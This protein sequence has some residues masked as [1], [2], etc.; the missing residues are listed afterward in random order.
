MKQVLRRLSRTTTAIVMMVALFMMSVGLA[1]AQEPAYGDGIIVDGDTSDW[2]LT[3]DFFANMYVAGNSNKQHLS[4]LYLRY[5]CS[6]NTLYALVLKETGTVEQSASD[7]WI[8]IN[9]VNDKRVNGSSGDDGTPPDF[10]WVFDNTTLL[11]YEASFTLAEGTYDIEAHLNI[12]WDNE[13]QTSSTG[14]LAQDNAIELT[15]DCP[16]PPVEVCTPGAAWMSE[17]S[18]ITI[19][20]LS[21]NSD[22]EGKT[23]VG[24]SLINSNSANFGLNFSVPATTPVLEI[25]GSGGSGSAINVNNGSVVV[26]DDNTITDASASPVDYDIN[27][28]RF[29]VNAGNSGATAST[30]GTLPAKAAQIKSDLEAWST[31]LAGLTANNSVTPPSGSPGPLNFEVN[32]KD[33][34]GVAVFNIAGS[35]LFNNSNVQQIEIKNNVNADVIIINVSGTTINWNHGNKVGSW[36]TSLNGRSKTIWN[37]PEAT[38]IDL[39]SKNF[40]GALLAPLAAVNAQA[41]IDGATAVKSLTTTSEVH[42]PVLDLGCDEEPPSSSITFIK[43]V[44]GGNASPTDWSFDITDGPQDIAHN[45]TQTLNT[46]NYII[47]E[48]GPEGYFLFGASGVCSVDNDTITLN[49]TTDGGTC[50]ITNAKIPE[51]PSSL[52]VTKTVN[53]S[54]VTP[55]EQQTFEICISGPSYPNG[56][57]DGACQDADFDGTTLSWDDLAEGEYIVAETNPGSEWTV[58]ITDSPATVVPGETAEVSVTNTLKTGSLDVTK[59]VNWNG[60]TPDEQQ[61]FEI[62]IS[63]PSYPNGDENGACQEADYDGETL[64]WNDLELG[65]YTVS[66]TNPGDEWT[67]EITGSPATVEADGTAEAT[68]TNTHEPPTGSITVVKEVVVGSTTSEFDFELEQPVAT[69]VGFVLTHGQD[70]TF[71]DLAPGEYVALETFPIGESDAWEAL[72]AEDI[73]CTSDGDST[74]EYLPFDDEADTFGVNVSLAAGDD[75]TCT[76]KNTEKPLTGS[77]EVTKYVSWNNVTPDESKTFEICIKGPSYPNG[78]EDGACQEADFDG[79]VL[80]WNKL[81]VGEYT[82]SETDPGDEWD[83]RITDSPATVVVNETVKAS[84]TNQYK[85][86]DLYVYKYHDLNGNGQYDYPDEPYLSDWEI[87]VYDSDEN[88]VGTVKTD[89]SGQAAFEYLLIGDYIV[90]ETQQD[91]WV[92]T[93]DSNDVFEFDG[94]ICQNQTIEEFSLFSVYF[95]NQKEIEPGKIT[96]IKFND[97]NQNGVKDDGEPFLADWEFTLKQG[98]T[99]IISDTT[100]VNG[101]VM[102]GDLEPGTYQVCE[103]MKDGWSNST[104]ICQEVTIGGGAAV[105]SAGIPSFTESMAGVRY[106]SFKNTGGEEVYLGLPDL[107]LVGPPTGDRRARNLTWTKPGTHLVTFSYDPVADKLITT[108]DLNND[109][110]VDET[111]T[112]ENFSTGLVNTGRTAIA[113]QMNV[114]EILVADR[115]TDSSV[116]FNEVMLNGQSLGDFSTGNVGIWGVTGFDFGQ[117]FTL[118]G[119]VVIDGPFSNSQEKSRVDIKIGTAPLMFGNYKEPEPGKVVAIKFNDLN[120]DGVK[121]EGEPFLADWEFTLKQ[122]ETAIISD[123]TDVNGMV[124]FGDLEPGTYQVCETMQDGWS[125]STPICQE[126]TIG[127]GTAVVSAGIPSFSES[128]AGVRYRSFKNTGGEEVYLGLPDLGLVGPPSGDRVARNL[129]WTKPGTHL[130]TFTYEPALDRL[131]TTVDLGNDSS[132]D[133]TLIYENFSTGLVNTGRTAIASQMNVMEILVADR[134][135]DSSVQFNEVML[136]GQ[137]L[138]DFSTGNVGIWGVTGFDF[139]QGFTLSGKVVID[140]PF[141]N[142]QEK[143]R[144]DIKI[145]TAPLM[146]GNYEVPKGKITIIKTANPADTDE[147]FSFTGDLGD[148]S[149]G[150]NGSQEFEVS[151][152]SYDVTEIDIPEFWTLLTVQCGDQFLPIIDSLDPLGRQVTIDVEAGE[153]LTCTFHN[154]RVNY[155][156][157]VEDGNSNKYYLPLVMR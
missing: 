118:S 145:G 20:N 1:Y 156:A 104:P 63:G 54:N 119:K 78:D 17:Y 90:C 149:L 26:D 6:D 106:R 14:K 124:M 62:C 4:T 82:V 85:V 143:S 108:I 58:E 115:D 72:T 10:Q 92:N 38:S 33:A 120:K 40:M 53:W 34:N 50:T 93:N 110:S 47:T 98:E 130:V 65:E 28:R 49:V 71:T 44:Q 35:D 117:G 2:N 105:V 64:T 79:D 70:K 152:G 102:F 97:V 81:E 151:A 67:V 142:S 80:T 18:L 129:S 12:N 125:N 122:G 9:A 135:T 41:N 111:L 76:F 7:A 11:G 138:G 101:M 36:L 107:G 24:G 8:A 56:N 22:V 132:V 153:E 69:T 55:D 94:K 95:A 48:D 59:V 57:E 144:V 30:D 128:M 89:D 45:S 25:A 66:E 140:G 32:T 131:V 91:G 60:V 27:G 77:L 146:F 114:M 123:T 137:S 75:V 87:T 39:K 5:D 121:D 61:T 134:D 37:F 133:E 109:S 96:A 19:E 23:F 13:S 157:P 52:Q 3:D 155:V 74:F 147:Q 112:Y 126:V 83:V 100:D 116:Q 68:V 31:S 46:G 127:G 42:L 103:T 150:A 51:I 73:V 16:E 86:G 21:T 113:S 15:L 154:E 99:A 148:F 139:G 29:N 88:F 141:S 43:E 84:V 136:N